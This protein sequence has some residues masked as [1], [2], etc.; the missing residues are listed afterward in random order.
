MPRTAR[1]TLLVLSAG[2]ILSAA[3]PT[4]A[5]TDP[6][7]QYEVH[8]GVFYRVEKRT[9]YG[10]EVKLF[11]GP[12]GTLTREQLRGQVA[13]QAPRVLSD[14]LAKRLAA[15]GKG[16]PL[17]VVVVMRAQPAE[18]ISRQVLAPVQ[19]RVRELSARMRAIS[20]RTN[21]L[22]DGGVSLP[23]IAEAMLAAGEP[24]PAGAAERDALARRIDDLMRD[25]RQDAA[26]RIAAAL[27]PEQDALA[28]R[29]TALGGRVTHRVSV[30]NVLGVVLPAGRVAELAAD[31]RIAHVGLN[32]P[33]VPELDTSAASIGAPTFWSNGV[34]GTTWD[35]AVLDTGCFQAHPAFAGKTFISNIG[36][37]DTGTH[38]TAMTGIFAS[39]NATNR[40]IAHGCDKI[41][42]SLAGTD[43]TSMTGMAF[44][45]STGEPE[46]CNYS[47]GNG[48]ASTNDY[49]P[50]DQFFDGVISSFDYIVSKS[51]GN[52]GFGSGNPTI[53]HPAPAF[54]LMAVANIDNTGDTNRANDRI[55]TSSSR[56]PTAA[57]RKKPDIGAPGTSIMTTN[58]SG[59][60]TA[61][62]GT[63]PA[64][65][66]IGSAIL[67]LAHLGTTDIK[68][69]KA[70]LINHTDA[71]DDRGT[72]STADD[73]F[74][75]GSFWNRRYGWGYVDLTRA[76]AH[77]LD[78]FVDSIP[79]RPENADFRLYA[80]RL[81][82]HEKVTLV[83]QRH[84][85]Y[86]GSTY[87]TQVESLSDLDLRCY[88]RSDNTLLAN[89]GSP[90]DNVEQFSLTAADET[91]VVKVEAFGTFDPDIT[92][93]EFALATQE[94]FVA[95]TGPAFT[96][97]INAPVSVVAGS[98][99]A[100]SA[101]VLNSGDL[102]AHAVT[103]QF[104]GMPVAVGANPAPLGT[105]AQGAG[106][107]ANWTVQAPAT[108]G[109]YDVT[110][111]VASSSYGETFTGLGQL[112]INVTGACRGDWNGDGVV[113]FNDFLAYLNDYNAGLPI[114][115]INGDGVVDFNDFL[116]FLNLYNTPC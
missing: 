10:A 27:G 66:H 65:P 53:T 71:M 14:G 50:I 82:Q 31:P 56:G 87:P 77:G 42:I 99:F 47:F 19:A 12:S 80:G 9:E 94:N 86:N 113:D 69:A 81:F 49:A 111:T 109:S 100:L 4:L 37:T 70:V 79:D 102:P 90:I 74:V 18:P 76:Y 30:S 98:T 105:I 89:A 43:A 58:T 11:H 103:A 97:T 101:S 110:V 104:A 68:A 67:L 107:I 63:S 48:T 55:N 21:P 78:V 24:D 88:R 7:P 106:P 29:V 38:G 33:G 72:S 116:E 22:A 92:S 40:G 112:T 54:N 3:A 46:A 6:W 114:A 1:T 16:A 61:V 44:I 26:R 57:G 36:V 23:P 25:A 95:A 34:I 28:A 13:A 73:I 35:A 15:V 108:P 84:V 96:P 20:A 32:N 41:V 93:E 8:N 64:A 45:A 59:G 52:G 115:D 5:A 60:F 91:V 75:D 62:T 17:E 83:W 39:T 51:T 2:T 85:A